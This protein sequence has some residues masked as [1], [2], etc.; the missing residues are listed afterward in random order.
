MLI[1]P[2]VLVGLV[3]L[4]AAVALLGKGGAIMIVLIILMAIT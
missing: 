3:P 2:S 1:L 4:A